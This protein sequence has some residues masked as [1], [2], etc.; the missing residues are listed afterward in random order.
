[1]TKAAAPYRAV[2]NSSWQAHEGPAGEGGAYVHP[3]AL[4]R[5]REA[6]QVAL[7]DGVFLPVVPAWVVPER[8]AGARLV[9]SKTSQGVPLTV[10]D[11]CLL[12]FGAS[13]LAEA[14]VNRLKRSV[15]ASGHL[16]KL[17][18]KPGHRP[19]V[20][21]FVT[22]T[23]AKADAWSARHISAAVEGFRQW[24]RRRHAP[25]RYTWVAEIQPKRCERTGQAVVHYH[26]LA[27]L[28]VGLPMP[29]WDRA[30]PDGRPCFWPHGRTERDEAR[31]GVGYLMK[32][33]SK[34]GEFH[35]FPKGLRLYGIGGL[36]ACGKSVRQWFNLPEW[37]KRLYGV[38]EVAR[39]AGRLVVRATGEVLASPW[40]AELV[41]GGMLLRLT[42]SLAP[43][44]H[45]GVYSRIGV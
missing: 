8:A 45:D 28:P 36:D 44:L 20:A 42:G 15:W 10:G 13:V 3:S 11:S 18:D 16:H 32:Y 29:K 38:G 35:R 22:L 41:P 6:R 40:T 33:L 19:P 30:T 1:M 43:R 17:A 21:W 26:L 37:A 24:C 31:S 23:Y 34:L 12:S 9:P 14:R 27:W 39:S 2:F 7:D 5:Q 4:V 25:C